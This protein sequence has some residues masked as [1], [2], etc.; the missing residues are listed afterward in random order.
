MRV[1]SKCARVVFLGSGSSRAVSP[2]CVSCRKSTQIYVFCHE[3]RCDFFARKPLFLRNRLQKPR[4]PVATTSVCGV[5]PLAAKNKTKEQKLSKEHN[6]CSC[7]D[8]CS[9]IQHLQQLID[10]HWFDF[11]A[12]FGVP[13]VAVIFFHDARS[14]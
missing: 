4:K 10:F 14:A 2:P 13:K 11:F 12:T 9:T 8:L 3:R 1:Q 7:E 5:N 6:F